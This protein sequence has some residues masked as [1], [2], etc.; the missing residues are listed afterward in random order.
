MLEL[1][2]FPCHCQL[3]PPITIYVSPSEQHASQICN[4]EACG[5]ARESLVDLLLRVYSAHGLRRLLV[6]PGRWMCKV[7]IVTMKPVWSNSFYTLDVRE[8]FT[9]G[10]RLRDRRMCQRLARRAPRRSVGLARH[11]DCDRGR[12]WD[13]DGSRLMLVHDGSRT[14]A[15]RLLELSIRPSD[16]RHRLLCGC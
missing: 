1:A 10:R 8:V 5:E 9:E 11:S 2:H 4:L 15:R 7:R 3:F 16:E 12:C 14:F 6:T 13:L